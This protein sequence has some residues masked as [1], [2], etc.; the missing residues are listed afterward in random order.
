[1][2]INGKVVRGGVTHDRSCS[3]HRDRYISRT[4][5]SV[6]GIGFGYANQTIVTLGGLRITPFLLH[7]I[8]Q[9]DYGLWLRGTQILTYLTLLDFGVITLLP[10]ETVYATGRAGGWDRALDLPEILGHTAKLVLCQLPVIALVAVALWFAIPAE[11]EALRRPA[12]MI[13]AVFTLLFP[14]RILPVVLQG[15]Q[16]LIFLGKI[17]VFSSLAN[18]AVGAGLVCAGR[19]C[20]NRLGFTYSPDFWPCAPGF[21]EGL[22]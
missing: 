4:Q 22:F 9:H 6:G 7:R 18:I 2:H 21:S 11:W 5:R 20:G 17:Q 3:S 10:R 19:R 14:L 1:M 8:G 16:D 13:L 12:A 15:L